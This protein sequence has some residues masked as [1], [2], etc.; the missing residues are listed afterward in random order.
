MSAAEHVT[1][2]RVRADEGRTLRDVRLA[3]LKESPAAFG[4]T[5]E[6]E[7]ARP[8]AEWSERAER[9]AAGIER[10]TFFA[11]VDDHVVGL[12]GGYRPDARGSTVDLV[13]MWTAPVAR[14]TGVARALVTA[15][16]DWATALSAATVQLWVTRGNEPALALYE[17]MGF[18]QTGEFQPLPSD[19]T[20]DELAMTRELR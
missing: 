6:A 19:P 20:R 13:S 16:L 4:S 10:V 3:A 5:Y 17:S 18:R 9:G 7:A 2:R 15:V 1:V 12:V 8:D 14:R 11:F